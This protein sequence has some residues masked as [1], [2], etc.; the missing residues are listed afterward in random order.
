MGAV[1]E[2]CVTVGPPL[3]TASSACI[4]CM[5]AALTFALLAL[6]VHEAGSTASSCSELQYRLTYLGRWL[7][8]MLEM[9]VVLCLCAGCT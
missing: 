1:K 8:T 7:C 2:F 6:S 4:R 5:L 9:H 3:L